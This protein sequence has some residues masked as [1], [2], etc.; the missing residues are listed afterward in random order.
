MRVQKPV[1]VTVVSLAL[2]AASFAVDVTGKW[3]GKVEMTS[4]DPKIEAKIKEQAAQMPTVVLQVKADHTYVSHSKSA[5]G[6]A[7]STEGKWELKGDKF[8]VTPTKR[9]GKPVTGDRPQLRAYILSKDGKTMTL[10]ISD[11]LK[12]HGAKG[13]V[14]IVM[15]KS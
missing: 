8:L 5:K 10:D 3:T 2:V 14:K 13:T 12:A 15:H 7:T 4:P 11:Q 9:D 6:Q 1:L